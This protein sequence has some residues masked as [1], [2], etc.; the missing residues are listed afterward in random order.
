LSGKILRFVAKLRMTGFLSIHRLSGLVG[1]KTAT[2]LP[3]LKERAVI[4]INDVF[5]CSLAYFIA[6]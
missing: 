6:M 3:C 1:G 5:L 4:R 2:N